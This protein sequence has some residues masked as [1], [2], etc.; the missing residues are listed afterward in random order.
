MNRKYSLPQMIAVAMIAALLLS[1][2]TSVSHAGIELWHDTFEDGNT[3]CWTIQNNGATIAV[4]PNTG[5]ES[6]K[7]L[8]VTGNFNTG[9]GAFAYSRSVPLDF[10]RDYTVQFAFRYDTF[11]WDR[12][13]IFGHI[14]LLIDTPAYPM[15]YDPNGT[16][17][18]TPVNDTD[19]GDYLDENTWAW[20]T[21]HC[22]PG[23]REYSIFIDGTHVATVT[24]QASVETS[25]QLWFEDNHSWTNHM[26]AWYDDFSIRGFHTPQT[27]AKPGRQTDVENNCQAWAHPPT[28]PYHGQYSRGAGHPLHE[29]CCPG[30]INTNP[31]GRCVVACLQM[32]F[33]AFGDPLPNPL[34]NPPGPQE[35]I[36]AAA[37]TNDRVDCDDNPGWHGTTCSDSRRAAHFSQ[38][39]Q[40]LTAIRAGC[41]P[42]GCPASPG[43]L[44]YTWRDLGYAA[45]DSIWI[46]LAPQ[47]S[48]LMAGGGAPLVLETL[49]AS[50]YPIIAF[51][52][53]PETYCDNVETD[54]QMGDDSYKDCSVTPEETVSGH[55]VLIIGYDNQGGNA[56]NQH[57]QPAF[58]IHDPAVF[59]WGWIP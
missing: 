14:R 15:R 33:D 9:Q 28:V 17:S 57:Q 40:A 8:K 50:G 48:I 39:T 56:G 51:I 53:P 29:P 58:L 52:T 47:D 55:A 11:H 43:A 10:N 1:G 16:D 34:Q 2:F 36:E 12:F 20:I 13:L 45:L 18:Y 19:F 21:V 3:N 25:S 42:A 44:G 32:I 41:P 22:R 26:T 23:P 27:Y 24:Y 35:E 31:N 37:N 59:K 7:S 46:E 49:L 38:A 54:T 30:Q 6:A 5:H 4:D